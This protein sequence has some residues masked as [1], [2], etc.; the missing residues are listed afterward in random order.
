MNSPD[1]VTLVDSDDNVLGQMDKV[2]AHRGEAKR[3]RAISV[4]LFRKNEQEEDAT[5][6]LIQQ[7]S[8]QKIVGANWWA[9]TV[10][11]NVR[12]TETYE[13][14]A[15]RRL[16][17]E[18]GITKIVIVPLY[19]FEYHLQCNAEFSEWEI[20]QVFVGWYDGDVVPNPDEVQDFSWVKWDKLLKKASEAELKTEE[21]NIKVITLQKQYTL[22]PWFVWMLGDGALIQKLQSL[23]E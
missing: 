13:Q 12:P 21:F 14:C 15:Y 8:V 19:K 23:A 7:R 17:E 10:C 20:D 11:G 9:N 18:L 5:Q 1:L 16:R 6:L 22:A 3:H 4:Y 2:E